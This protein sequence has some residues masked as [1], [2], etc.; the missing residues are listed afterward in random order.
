MT[1]QR[2]W[3][4]GGFIVTAAVEPA[5]GAAVANVAFTWSPGRPRA[6]TVSEHAEL[7][8]HWLRFAG[9]LRR[10]TGSFAVLDAADRALVAG[11]AIQR[12]ALQPAEQPSAAR[13]STPQA[14][15]PIASMSAGLPPGKK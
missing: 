8:E 12:E 7:R 15:A 10:R 2:V 4:I 14:A 5:H 13:P 6:L 1:Q 11:D 3:D 9:E